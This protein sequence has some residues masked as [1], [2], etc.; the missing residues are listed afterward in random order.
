MT[1]DIVYD[2]PSY[3]NFQ[4]KMEKVQYRACLAITGRIQETSREHPYN[5][6]G[7]HALVKNA[8]TINFL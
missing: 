2:K 1:S 3:D 6:L 4:K 5:E 7:L 8:A